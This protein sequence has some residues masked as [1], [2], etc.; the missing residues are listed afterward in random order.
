LFSKIQ[1][2]LKRGSQTMKNKMKVLQK[3][4]MAVAVA[5]VFTPLSAY[6]QLEEV[7]VTA[8]KREQNLQ[9][10]PIAIS[11][12]SEEMIVKTGV[13][14]ISQVIPMVPGVTGSDYGLATNTW[15]IRGISSNDWTIGSEPSV[16]VFFDDA[17]VGRN[18]FATGVFFD[19]NRIEVVK[20][21]QGTLFG[22]NAA[23]GAISLVSN[24]PSDENE[25]NLGI[26]Y[27]DEGQLRYEVIGNLAASDTFAV[28]LAYQ[29]DEWE[30]MW[31]EVN[32]GEDA[33][34]ES[35]TVR[36][37]ARWSPSDYFEAILRGNYSEA[38][39]N[40]TSALNTDL[41]TIAP[42]VEYPDKYAVNHPNDEYNENSG[43]G[44]RLTWNLSDT[45]TLVSIT[46]VRTGENDYLEDADGTDNDAAVDAIYGPITG[47]ITIPYSGS[48]QLDTTYQEFRLSGG[49]EVLTWFAGVSYYNEESEAP[50]YFVDLIDTAFGL[51]SLASIVIANE[52]DNDSYGAYGDATWNV[53]DNFALTGGVRYSYDEKNWCTN[54]IED[55]F[56]DAGGP[57]DGQLCTEEDWSEVTSRLVGQYNI[58]D[59]VMVFASVAEGYKGGGF[60]NSAADTNGDFMGDTIVPFDPETSIAYE[61]GIKSMLM[62]GKLQL[63]ASA[64]Y[65]EFDD[66]Q[67]QTLS[68]EIGQ[69]ISNGGD[70]E[71]S[72]LEAELNYSPVDGLVLLANYA[73]LD[74]EF[75]QGP[76]EGNDMAYAPENTFSV[77]ANLDHQFLGGTLNWFAIYNYT[78]D[79][80]H[81]AGN[82]SQEDAYG[83]LNARVSYTPTDGNW[84]LA[85]AGDNL[86]DE[87]YGA[88]RGDLGLGE[89]IHWGYKRMIRAEFNIR[90]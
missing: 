61:L 28:R 74:A 39:T 53:T 6:A 44:L 54:T 2:L 81:D 17:Y 84:E 71:T 14:T 38:E 47:G 76:L 67:I 64:F 48:I 22:R 33:Y 72:G 51:G 86:T 32:S 70:A 52:G 87:G 31:E 55:G 18:A 49:E 21:P 66:L 60:N 41:S 29:H 58:S 68:I 37:S 8:Q 77:G 24:K 75:V 65:T 35:D 19:I 45:M 46:D 34:Q 20:G 16:G 88:F 13:N 27:G 26:A 30:G 79:F 90:F 9:E 62:D 36:L 11:A 69:Q 10:V 57:T 12:V 7:V 82:V 85:L 63:N 83:L 25:L 89:Q 23:A 43:V 73:Y 1:H 15:A 50:D 42:G 4:V 78:D 80:Y 59:D 3:T 56:G 40:Y 5:S